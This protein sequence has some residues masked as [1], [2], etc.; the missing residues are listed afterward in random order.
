M[1]YPHTPRSTNGAYC[2]G[3]LHFGDKKLPVKIKI[4]TADRSGPF[5]ELTHQTRAWPED[6][7]DARRQRSRN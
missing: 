6:D 4:D 5:I 3:T 7:L 2:D 1:S